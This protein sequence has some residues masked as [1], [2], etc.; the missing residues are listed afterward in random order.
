MLI[1]QS[2]KSEL[3]NNCKIKSKNKKIK[4]KYEWKIMN[5]IKICNIQH[6]KRQNVL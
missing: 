1:S 3:E 4:N 5:T 6:N 2:S